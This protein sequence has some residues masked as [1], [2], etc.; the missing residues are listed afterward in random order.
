[1]EI[2]PDFKENYRRLYLPSIPYATLFRYP[3]GNL[4]PDRETVV[5]AI[6]AAKKILDFIKGRISA[7]A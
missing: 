5:K 4:M 2:D 3:E 6:A 7:G 1:M